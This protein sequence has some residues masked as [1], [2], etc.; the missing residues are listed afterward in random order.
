MSACYHATHRVYLSLLSHLHLQIVLCIFPMYV[1]AVIFYL[2]L[3]LEEG[4]EGQHGHTVIST[5]AS[6]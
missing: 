5:A 6:Q 2:H 1:N 3:S 4:K